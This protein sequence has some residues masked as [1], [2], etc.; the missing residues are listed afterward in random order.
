MLV[1]R[2]A[3]T[4]AVIMLMILHTAR[5]VPIAVSTVFRKLAVILVFTTLVLMFGACGEQTERIVAELVPALAEQQKHTK[6]ILTMRIIQIVRLTV[7]VMN[8]TGL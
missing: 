2:L 5:Y 7:F 6:P 4:A 3:E 8:V 1:K